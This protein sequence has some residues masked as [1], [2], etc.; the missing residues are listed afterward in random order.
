MVAVD[1]AVLASYEGAYEGDEL[2][3]T[4]TTKDGKVI[5]TTDRWALTFVAADPVTFRAEEVPGLKVSFQAEAGKVNGMTLHR[6]ETAT[7]L[8]KKVTP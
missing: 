2:Q 8:R 6:G 3:V 5:V 1:P 7:P 4:V